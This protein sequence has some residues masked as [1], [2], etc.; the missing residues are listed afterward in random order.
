MI[1]Y[2]IKN[3]INISY[4]HYSDWFEYN[5][6]SLSPSI[7]YRF[8]IQR[9]ES[10]DGYFFQN[11]KNYIAIEMSEVS[12]KNSY[13]SNYLATISFGQSNKYYTYFKRRY[14]KIQFLLADIMSVINI[15][16]Q[17]GKIIS[18]FLLKKK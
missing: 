8:E 1:Y 5:Q 18:N 9:Y 6:N 11:S 16:I 3:P 17:I 12:Y 2:S 14:Q 13:N 7:N 10:D 4:Y 15:L